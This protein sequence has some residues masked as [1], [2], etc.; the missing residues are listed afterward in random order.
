MATKTKRKKKRGG[1]KKRMTAE[2]VHA[3]NSV[4]EWA[5]LGHH[6]S[7]SS[8]CGSVV[9]DDDFGVVVQKSHSSSSSS[10][11]SEKVVFELHSH[12]ICSDGYLSPSKLVERAHGNGVSFF[13]KKHL[14]VICFE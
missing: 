11:V 10:R 9:V 12:S 5:F 3:S 7:S 6:S 2:Q 4:H 13:K 8:S 14:F 1:T